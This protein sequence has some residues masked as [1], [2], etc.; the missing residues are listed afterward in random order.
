MDPQQRLLLEVSYVAIEDSGLLPSKLSGK[1]V[2]VFI[3]IA[4][5]DYSDLQ[6]KG[7]AVDVYTNTGSANSIAANRISYFFNCKGPCFSVDTAC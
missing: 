1:K 2:G 4:G 7:S 5:H 6:Q 3:G